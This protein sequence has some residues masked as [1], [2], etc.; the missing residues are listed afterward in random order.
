VLH[1]IRHLARLA[2][3][4]R[5]SASS[6]KTGTTKP[7]SSSPLTRWGRC[8]FRACPPDIPSTFE[9]PPF[10]ARI[11]YRRAL[12]PRAF[13]LAAQF[14]LLQRLEV[15]DSSCAFAPRLWLQ[16]SLYLPLPWGRSPPAKSM[17]SKW[18]LSNVKGIVPHVIKLSILYF[19]QSRIFS[20]D[21]VIVAGSY[22]VVL[23]RPFCSSEW[24]VGLP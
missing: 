22:Q 23:Q 4:L 12:Y 16:A 5:C 18:G 17:H 20:N 8:Y 7:A 11:F 10:I 24:F 9:N 1:L 19:N 3:R 15:V 2:A 6:H 13:S 21:N 14:T